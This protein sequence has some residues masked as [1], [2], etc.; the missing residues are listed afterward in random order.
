MVVLQNPYLGWVLEVFSVL[1]VCKIWL[2]ISEWNPETSFSWWVGSIH[3]GVLVL[4]IHITV[5]IL[6]VNLLVDKENHFLIKYFCTSFVWK[7]NE[8]KKKHHVISWRY[9]IM[10]YALVKNKFQVNLDITKHISGWNVDWSLTGS[11]CWAWRWLYLVN[12]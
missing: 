1:L 4:F 3:A 6:C 11:L 12:I 7:E 8:K 2:F 10:V 5:S 9:I